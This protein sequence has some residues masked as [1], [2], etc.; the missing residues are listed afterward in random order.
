MKIKEKIKEKMIEL[1]ASD[2]G[3]LMRS[4]DCL[5]Q[6]TPGG[7]VVSACN[8]TVAYRRDKLLILCDDF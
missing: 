8:N 6:V 2:Y 1:F 4:D 3:P 5:G 7:Y